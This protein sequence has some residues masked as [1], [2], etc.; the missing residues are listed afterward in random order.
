MAV[1]NEEVVRLV[2]SLKESL[3]KEMRQLEARLLEQMDMRLEAMETKL[4]TEFHKWASPADT[5]LRGHAG[6]LRSLQVD[7]EDLQDG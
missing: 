5:K 2:T 6:L 1:E 7:L 3:E 4:L